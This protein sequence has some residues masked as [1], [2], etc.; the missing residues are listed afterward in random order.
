MS[1]AVAHKARYKM[2]EPVVCPRPNIVGC[3]AVL[4]V[5]AFSNHVHAQ[6]LTVL[7]DVNVIDGTGAAAQRNRTVIIAGDR[8]QSILSGEAS[9]PSEAKVIDMQGQTI[10]PLIINTHG[11]LGLVK[12]TSSSAA[13]QTDDNIRR[14]LLRYHE[15]GVGA[16]LSMGTDGQKFAEVREASRRGSLPGA[17]VFSA[18]IGMGAK[19]GVPPVTMGFTTVLRPVTPDE[20]RKYVAQQAPLKPDFIKSGSMFSGDNTR[21]SCRLEFTKQSLP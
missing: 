11:H 19:D 8:I 5:L 13:N 16:V 6:Q 3:L 1:V 14:Q 9:T 4:V 15:Y 21:T 10:M 2:F 20:G 12:G 18:G 17:D 7:K